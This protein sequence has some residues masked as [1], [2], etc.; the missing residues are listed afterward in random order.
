LEA[1]NYKS[2]CGKVGQEKGVDSE[3]LESM[4]IDAFEEVNKK[5]ESFESLRYSI[6]GLLTFFYGKKR[7]HKLLDSV[8][9]WGKDESI[10]NFHTFLSRSNVEELKPKIN[11][12]I[13]VYEQYIEEK[14]SIKSSQD[15]PQ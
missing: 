8:E 1:G 2:L 15:N 12:L 14:K 7:L 11:D 4:F 6:R 5:M 3:I 13:N 10:R 9:K